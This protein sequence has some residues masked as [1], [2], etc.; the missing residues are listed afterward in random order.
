MNVQWTA[1]QNFSGTIELVQ[2]GIVVASKTASVTS[3]SP[4][5][6]T[7]T[8]NF[9]KS[10]WLVAR[11]MATSGGEHYV[12]TA[13]V[14][15]TVNNAPV[16]ASA[17]D[18]QFYVDWMNNLLTSTSAGGQWSSFFPTQ[19]SAA[20][21]RY[22]SAKALFQQIV[23]EANGS[24]STLSSI[25]VSPVNK[26][27]AAG[28]QQSY[29]ASGTYSVGTLNITAQA[30]WTSSNP[31]VA[32]VN[33]RGL[34]TA[35]G[36][37]TATITATLNGVSGSTTLSVL[38]NPLTITTQSL[39]NGTVGTS[40]STTLAAS[41]G[42][43]PYSWSISGGALPSGLTLNSSTGNISWNANSGGNIQFHGS[44]DGFGQPPS[45]CNR[46]LELSRFQFGAV[47]NCPC[48]IWPST[49]QPGIPDSGPD[50]SVEIGVKFRADQNGFITGIRF[51]K[52]V[53]NTGTHVG[54]LWS[55][56]WHA[57]GHGHVQ[58]GDFL[59]L[60][61][62]SFLVTGSRHRQ[63]HLCGVVPCTQWPLL[64]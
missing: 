30:R 24:A 12:H 5:T 28:T 59:R 15:V 21:A 23:A 36:L 61:A 18:A 49:A 9:A 45:Q 46:S 52:G 37:G 55:S 1:T 10:G 40:Y 48:T 47:A 62:G 20:Q 11:R 56:S 7:A 32:T 14:F 19:R 13:A 3:T 29:T 54:N 25:T 16:R 31:S 57:A 4:A 58:W 22:Q 6:L 34:V 8:V 44:G 50:S 17:A 42:T 41:G 35:V 53:G 63:H 43:T 33:P 64:G 38:T 2:N 60:A 39:P 26:S 51:Y 27:I